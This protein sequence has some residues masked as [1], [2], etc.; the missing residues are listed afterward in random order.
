GTMKSGSVLVFSGACAATAAIWLA[1]WP[2]DEEMAVV[3]RADSHSPKRKPPEISAVLA[4]L[5]R[6]GSATGQMAAAADLMRISDEEIRRALDEAT[7]V[8]YG[9][10]ALAAKL[11]L[12]RWGATD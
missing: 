9:K 6:A 12:V 7:L 3:R 5:E 10:L 4:D 1:A 11:L 2:G 8:E